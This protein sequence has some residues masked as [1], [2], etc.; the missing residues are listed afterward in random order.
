MTASDL[1]STLS[2]S[3][4]LQ[5]VCRE[6]GC[7]QGHFS[8]PAFGKSAVGVQLFLFKETSGFW[9]IQGDVEAIELTRVGDDLFIREVDGPTQF[10]GTLDVNSESYMGNVSQDGI[11]DGAFALKPHKKANLSAELCQMKV[12]QLVQRALSDGFTQDDIDM[13]LNGD[14]PKERLISLIFAKHASQSEA[15]E[16]TSPA[17]LN[18]YALRR[19]RR[20]GNSAVQRRVFNVS[21]HGAHQAHWERRDM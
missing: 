2:S 15:K 11:W 13:L 5:Q 3:S 17:A 12:I 16:E 9:V 1:D 8:H 20:P 19:R 10:Q 7:F 6:C 14:R 4:S 21:T 18:M